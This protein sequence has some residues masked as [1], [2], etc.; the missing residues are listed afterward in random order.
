MNII[1]LFPER[2]KCDCS[3]HISF[4]NERDICC[5]FENLKDIIQF[6]QIKFPITR[7]TSFCLTLNGDIISQ[8]IPMNILNVCRYFHR[9]L[10]LKVTS[11][12]ARICHRRKL[13][14]MMTTSF[15]KQVYISQRAYNAKH[16]SELYP[17]PG[18]ENFCAS[19]TPNPS[20]GKVEI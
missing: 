12:D 17:Q 13:F 7:S 15:L 2:N 5:P 9:P 1:T 3:I 8:D 6:V 10:Q 14:Q 18:I 16:M 19:D 20:V 4:P 11:N